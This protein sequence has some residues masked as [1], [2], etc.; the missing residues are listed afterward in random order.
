MTTARLRIGVI[1]DG[2]VR[3][4]P[5][6]LS[7]AGIDPATVDPRT[8]A[9]S[10]L[11]Q[12]VAIRVTGESD[13]SFDGVDQIEFYGQR[14][15]GTEM[16]EKY[17]DERVYW[18]D[19]GGTA[20]P[21]IP[22]VE[23]TPQ[24]D[25]TPPADF[26]TTL[27]AEDNTIWWS[28]YTLSPDTF[29]TWFWNR[30][31][32]LGAGQGVT[33]S[34]PYTVPD[35]APGFTAALR[36]VEISRFSEPHYSTLALNGV[37]LAGQSWSGFVRQVF[38]ATV[39]AGLLASG[40][41]TVAA[42]AWNEPGQMRSDS[43]ER[44]D[45]S[46]PQVRAILAELAADLPSEPGSDPMGALGLLGIAADDIFVNYWELDY[47]RLFRAWE[48][49]L[50]FTAEL[51]GTQEFLSEGWASDD[52]SIWDISDPLQPKRQTGAVA[53]PTGEAYA[54]RFRAAPAAGARFWLQSNTA[55][56]SRPAS[57]RL[58]PPP[59]CAIQPAGPTQ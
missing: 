29:D 20:G 14:F 38:T 15:R 25:L 23:A 31:Q 47:R 33:V 49:Q 55:A 45:L 30:L 11:G 28:R 40:I 58:R 24:G 26:P 17:T 44:P 6:D 8:F 52:V 7:A 34:L 16:E 46:S 5:A 19:M 59:A 4:T 9:M 42:G 54:I 18:L 21:R 10:S 22:D 27:H 12:P 48:G 3:I 39:P 51:S 2:I 43:G 35:P 13:G 37:A 36:L 1:T 53:S 32:P 50:D 56:P 57:V 41:N